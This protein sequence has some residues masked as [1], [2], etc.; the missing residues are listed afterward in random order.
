MVA[1]HQEIRLVEPVLPGQPRV[2]AAV[3]QP[4]FGR[5]WRLISG[6]VNPVEV[7]FPVDRPGVAHDIPVRLVRRPH[8]E[9]GRTPH[10]PPGIAA[11]SLFGKEFQRPYDVPFKILVAGKLRKVSRARR[12]DVQ[13][14]RAGEAQR[15]QDRRLRR[16]RNHLQVDES[17]VAVFAAQD[18]GGVGQ[19]L[20]GVIRRADDPGGEENADQPLF[21]QIVH[22]KLRGFVRRQRTAVRD[23]VVAQRTVTAV[24]RTRV[25]EQRL[26]HDSVAARRERHRVEPAAVELTAAAVLRRGAAGAGEVV[27]GVLR[28]QGQFFGRVQFHRFFRD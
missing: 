3:V 18:R 23:A 24:A 19:Q 5:L 16:A 2:V 11:G 6:K 4:E 26:E 22:E 25:G 8:D 21:A 9:L 14:N 20:H 7:Q 10:R 1:A 27:S 17:P 15:P 28:Q 12:F 13:R